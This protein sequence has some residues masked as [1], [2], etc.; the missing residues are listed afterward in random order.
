MAEDRRTRRRAIEAARPRRVK[1]GDKIKAMGTV[2]TIESIFYQD[3]Y[4]EYD[5]K[6]PDGYWLWDIEFMDTNQHY[7]H[8]KQF[9]DKGEVIYNA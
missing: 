8:W 5:D 2:A 9:F 6:N 7:R 4:L 3:C 1:A